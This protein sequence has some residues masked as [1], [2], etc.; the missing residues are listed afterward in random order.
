MSQNNSII[1]ISSNPGS[2]KNTHKHT[3]SASNKPS[4]AIIINNTQNLTHFGV[5]HN[6]SVVNTD[7]TRNRVNHLGTSLVK[8]TSELF[9]SASRKQYRTHVV[10][11]Q[12]KNSCKL[13]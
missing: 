5:K 11:N 4:G 10:Q 9:K 1:S 7:Q 6:S 12:P 8:S 13:S 3:K 2:K